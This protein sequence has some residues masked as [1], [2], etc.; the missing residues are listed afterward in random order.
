LCQVVAQDVQRVDRVHTFA[1]GAFIT[2]TFTGNPGYVLRGP[3][4]KALEVDKFVTQLRHSLFGWQI[5]QATEEQGV[6]DAAALHFLQQCFDQLLISVFA[7]GQ[8]QTAAH[9]V[10]VVGLVQRQEQPQGFTQ[11]FNADKRR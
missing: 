1:A 2:H 4:I 9:Q 3:F 7:G 10:G 11:G 8:A 6:V 5:P